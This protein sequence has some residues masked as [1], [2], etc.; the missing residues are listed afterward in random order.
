M[1]STPWSWP[2]LALLMVGPPLEEW[3]WA[4][5]PSGAGLG[6]E[7]SLPILVYSTL[8]EKTTSLAR[9]CLL[10]KGPTGKTSHFSFHLIP[11]STL[12]GKTT[13][14]ARACLSP[15]DPTG[16]TLHLPFH[17]NTLKKTRKDYAFRRQFNE[18]PS[19]IP[20]CPGILYLTA[21]GVEPV[22]THQ[23]T[24]LENGGVRLH[25]TPCSSHSPASG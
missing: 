1:P 17:F 23:T 18:K 9:A 8:A 19:M 22:V 14:L 15:K 5:G 4:W 7:G 16:K 6:A 13:S 21:W 24:W 12:A 3:A 20:G 2:R 11:Y 25:Q 10:P